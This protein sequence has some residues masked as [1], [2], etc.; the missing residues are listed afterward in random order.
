LIRGNV[1]VKSQR[2]KLLI[3]EKRKLYK[4]LVSSKQSKY[5]SNLFAKADQKENWQNINKI[6]GRTKN[7]PVP[8]LLDEHSNKILDH[9]KI[10]DTMNDFFGSI[11]TNTTQNLIQPDPHLPITPTRRN[12]L[13]KQ[14][15]FPEAF[16]LTEVTEQ[17]IA[18]IGSRLKANMKG[19]TYSIPSKILQRFILY[20]LGQITHLINFSFH[21]SIFPRMFKEAILTPLY[22]GKGPRSEPGNYRPI[23]NISFLAKI[24]EKTVKNQLTN[25]LDAS[26]FHSAAQFGF[27]SAHSAE[28]A[29]AVLTTHIY[30]SIDK[31]NIILG[32]SLD[33]RKAFDCIDHDTLIEVMGKSDFSGESINWFASYLKDRPYRT[34]VGSSLSD[35]TLVNI[36]CPQGTIIAPVLFLIILNSFFL[37]TER[38]L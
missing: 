12:P 21:T 37:S 26:D 34:R 31:K 19:A 5:F 11:G 24:I 36:G 28:M 8:S 3:R 15:V 6:I 32:I 4:G 29:A 2:V 17:E 33:I 10:A 9:K 27:R 13:N 35:V 14:M 20:F 1:Y 7:P 16:A 30:D 18:K 25:F 23:S 38:V 22:K